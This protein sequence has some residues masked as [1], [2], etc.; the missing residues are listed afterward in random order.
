VSDGLHQHEISSSKAVSRR[1]RVSHRICHRMSGCNED[2]QA[3]LHRHTYLQGA[4]KRLLDGH[5]DLQD[6]EQRPRHERVE[7]AVLVCG[8]SVRC[9]CEE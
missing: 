7:R 1:Q 9:V 8:V 3:Q 2:A 6:A 5:A 4:L